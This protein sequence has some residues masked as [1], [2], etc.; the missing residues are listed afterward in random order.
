MPAM[1]TPE[2]GISQLLKSWRGNPKHPPGERSLIR[3]ACWKAIRLLVV[4]AYLWTMR[5]AL[6]MLVF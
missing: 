1:T 5:G 2:S 6:V 3:L 4:L